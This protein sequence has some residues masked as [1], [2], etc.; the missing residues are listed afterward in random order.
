MKI[1]LPRLETW[2]INVTAQRAG[3]YDAAASFNVNYP[4]EITAERRARGGQDVRII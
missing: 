1:F 2:T 3:A 4:Q